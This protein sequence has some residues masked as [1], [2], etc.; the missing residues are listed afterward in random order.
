[1]TAEKNKHKIVLYLI[2]FIVPFIMAQVYFAI[3]GLYPYG[4]N[5]YGHSGAVTSYVSHN[6]VIETEAF[7]RVYLIA[8]TSSSS[9]LYG[10]EST[11]AAVQK[12]LYGK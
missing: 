5:A 6:V 11:V 1:M 8:S 12:E 9:G 2:A 3:C 7:G 4:P 10:L